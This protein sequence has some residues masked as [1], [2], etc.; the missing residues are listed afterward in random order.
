MITRLALFTT[1]FLAFAAPADE[2]PAF[3][4]DMASSIS[5]FGKIAI[6]ASFGIDIPEGWAQDADG[7]SVTDITRRDEAIGQPPLPLLTRNDMRCW[8]IQKSDIFRI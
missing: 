1:A 4:I 6:A 5:S 2:E 7:N 8:L 3:V